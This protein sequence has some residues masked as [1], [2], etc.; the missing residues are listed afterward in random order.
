[1]DITRMCSLREEEIE[2][3]ELVKGPAVESV[4]YWLGRIC[5]LTM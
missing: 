3:R 1:M 4:E 5:S 2:T